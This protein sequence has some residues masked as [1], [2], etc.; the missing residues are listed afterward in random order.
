MRCLAI[1][2]ALNGCSACVLET[3]AAEPLAMETLPIERGHAEA[4]LPLVERVM[5]K[6]EG[7]F[8]SLDRVAVTVGPGSFT[9]LRVGL[10]AARAI[11]GGTSG[12]PGRARRAS[13]GCRG[14]GR[15]PPRRPC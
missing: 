2:T 11:A 10:S 8:G 7:G 1:D 6:V 3:G 13:A 12:D 15:V 14:P 4:L 9:G 5:A